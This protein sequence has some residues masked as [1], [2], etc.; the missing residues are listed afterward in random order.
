MISLAAIQKE[1]GNN[2]ILRE[3]LLKN[4]VISIPKT[5]PNKSEDVQLSLQLKTIPE[6]A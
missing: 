5:T 2:P 4:L 6:K 1:I 3:T